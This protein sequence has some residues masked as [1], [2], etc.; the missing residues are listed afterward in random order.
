MWSEGGGEAA[1]QGGLMKEFVDRE[2]AFRV[3][4]FEVAP[5]ADVGELVAVHFR[6]PPKRGEA[7]ALEEDVDGVRVAL[8]RY[9]RAE[10]VRRGMDDA[11][12]LQGVADEGGVGAGAD[13]LQVL[14]G[15]DGAVHE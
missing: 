9:G 3:V 14:V 8:V 7:G 6:Q 5:E 12:V 10:A 1:G 4:V 15:L 11:A 2:A 13:V